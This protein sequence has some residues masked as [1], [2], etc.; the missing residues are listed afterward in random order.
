MQT[1]VYSS[2]AMAVASRP[3]SARARA[4]KVKRR[5]RRSGLS[6]CVSV[7]VLA[8]TGTSMNGVLSSAM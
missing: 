7:N 8:S 5:P 6:K 2:Q 3:Q 4:M 1:A